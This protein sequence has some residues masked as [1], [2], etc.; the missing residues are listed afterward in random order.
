MVIEPISVPYFAWEVIAWDSWRCRIKLKSNNIEELL[1][2]LENGG[3]LFDLIP[4]LDKKESDR[5]D[6][7]EL[8]YAIF[9]KREEVNING[10][11]F[12]STKDY[13]EVGR[14]IVPKQNVISIDKLKIE[15]K[16][17]YVENLKK[18]PNTK[19]FYDCHRKPLP[20]DAIILEDKQ[21]A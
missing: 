17:K 16:E 8:N 5:F 3:N 2:K 20:K 1:I 7:F 11:D 6:K 21:I 19:M 14:L 12:V 15:N 9:E 4:G 18:Y 10:E 13:E